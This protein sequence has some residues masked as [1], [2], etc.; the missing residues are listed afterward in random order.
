ME[1][2]CQPLPLPQTPGHWGEIQ[3]REYLVCWACLSA[4][5][6]QDEG[7]VPGATPHG[8]V[9]HWQNLNDTWSLGDAVRTPSSAM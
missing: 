4:T 6:L 2:S 3:H 9:S 5:H 1:H 8:H 7:P